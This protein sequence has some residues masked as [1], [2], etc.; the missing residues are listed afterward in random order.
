VARQAQLERGAALIRTGGLNVVKPDEL[1]D[2]R[3]PRG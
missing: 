3:K 2:L 1:D